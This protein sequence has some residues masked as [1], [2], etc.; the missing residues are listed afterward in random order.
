MTESNFMQGWLTLI[1][2]LAIIALILT[3][4]GLMLGVVKPADA[5]KRVGAILGVA[6][7]LIFIPSLLVSAWSGISLWQQ[8]ALVAIGIVVW[9]WL[10]PRPRMH[11]RSRD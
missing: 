6:I 3:A 10:R 2:S 11:K 7:L 4:F 1:G 8:I 5:P 9:Q